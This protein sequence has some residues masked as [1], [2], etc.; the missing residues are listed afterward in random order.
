MAA[1]KAKE[2]VSIE[3]PAIDIQHATIRL[4]GDTPLIMHKWSE[5]AKKEILDKQMQKAKSKAHEPKNPAED[6]IR[7]M[8]WLSGEPDEMTMESFYQ[9]LQNGARFGFQAVAFKAAAVNA[10]YRA[11]IAKDKVSLRAAFHIDADLLEIKPCAGKRQYEDG[12][13]WGPEMREDMVTIGMGTAD[14]R[15]RG[16][17]K[18][19]CCDVPIRYNRGAMSFE[20]IVSLFNMG[21]FA[22]GVGEWRIEKGGTFGSFHVALE[23]DLPADAKL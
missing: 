2:T 19:W 9:A 14:I 15:Y 6:F 3:L 10:G 18:D 22:C 7:S 13:M 8:Y 1:K 12:T 23:S 16:E 11:G 20:Q 21:G 17:F 4:I 5:K